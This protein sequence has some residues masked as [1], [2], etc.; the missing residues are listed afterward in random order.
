MTKILVIDDDSRDRELLATVLEERGYEVILAD[1]GG[2]GLM[3][4]H[5]RDPDAVVLDLH[6]PGIDGHHLLRQLQTLHPSLPVV[7]FSG[8]GPGEVE[9]DVLNHGATAFIQKAFSL[10][11]FGLALQEVLP[12]PSKRDS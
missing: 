3:L 8:C 4:C 2:T 10:D 12:A 6:M 1:S 9:Q 7:V 11:Q 5:R